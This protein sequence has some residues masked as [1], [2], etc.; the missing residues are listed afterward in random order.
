MHDRLSLFAERTRIPRPAPST[1]PGPPEIDHRSDRLTSIE[2]SL[3]RAR[4]TLSNISEYLKDHKDSRAGLNAFAQF[5][6]SSLVA[7]IKKNTAEAAEPRERG[8]TVGH[9]SMSSSALVRGQSQSRLLSFYD[10]GTNSIKGLNDKI[11]A[12]TLAWERRRMEA[13][14]REQDLQEGITSSKPKDKD[15][16][17][18]EPKIVYCSYKSDVDNK[19]RPY[20]SQ[21]AGLEEMSASNLARWL[22]VRARSRLSRKSDRVVKI[23]RMQKLEQSFLKIRFTCEQVLS[24]MDVIDQEDEKQHALFI[25]TPKLTDALEAMTHK[26]WQTLELSPDDEKRAMLVVSAL[27][28]EATAEQHC[29]SICDLQ[30]TCIAHKRSGKIIAAKIPSGFGTTR[31]KDPIELLPPPKSKVT[32][33]KQDV[34]SIRKL[35]AECRAFV[36]DGA[37]HVTGAADQQ[38]LA[39]NNTLELKKLV[40]K[41]EAV[42]KM[43]GVLTAGMPD[44]MLRGRGGMVNNSDHGFVGKPEYLVH[45][46]LKVSI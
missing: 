29:K 33:L 36:E 44:K 8:D 5:S 37:A 11:N 17:S 40:G 18:N 45:M 39:A 12:L 14:Q 15:E 9:M 41:S 21:L 30:H 7:S 13:M 35:I 46:K 32:E 6:L 43:R 10:T 38:T 31:W 2:S 1:P 16:G 22:A 25:L 20:A 24:I 34:Q 19:T 42:S 28:A 23:E 27:C 4:V 3:S 26:I